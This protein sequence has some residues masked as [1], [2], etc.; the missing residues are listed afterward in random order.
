MLAAH[1]FLDVAKDFVTVVVG[2]EGQFFVFGDEID[3]DF[4]FMGF[5]AI[6]E[7]FEFD[8]FG[9]GDVAGFF[10]CHEITPRFVG[11]VQ[12]AFLQDCLEG[13]DHVLFGESYEVG[14]GVTRH[15]KK[16]DGDNAVALML[17]HSLLILPK[18]RPFA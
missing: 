17:R 3:L 8:E 6:K 2:L 14:A 10:L 1:D 9:K 4:S 7:D 16:V 11:E 15:K 13:C 12:V 5:V 18:D